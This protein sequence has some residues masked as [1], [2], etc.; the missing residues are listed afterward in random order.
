MGG[1]ELIE[2]LPAPGEDIFLRRS[3]VARGFHLLPHGRPP[4]WRQRA[5]VL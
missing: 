3:G 1:R 2:G 5:P 4:P